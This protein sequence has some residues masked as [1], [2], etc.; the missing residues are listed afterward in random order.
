MRFLDDISRRRVLAD[1]FIE[2]DRFELI[3]LTLGARFGKLECCMDSDRSR[4]TEELHTSFT[5]LFQNGD[6]DRDLGLA[7]L[8][9]SEVALEDLLHF[10][11][12]LEEL[13]R[14]AMLDEGRKKTSEVD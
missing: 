5:I 12:L 10:Y 13:V 14:V 6:L 1:M 7:L 9:S 4:R 3:L 8:E 2:H 11:G